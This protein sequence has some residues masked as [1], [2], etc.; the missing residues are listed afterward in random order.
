MDV[1]AWIETTGLTVAQ[2]IWIDVPAKPYIRFTDYIEAG[3]HTL[4]RK[5]LTHN[6]TIELYSDEVDAVSES[7]I[8]ALLSPLDERYTKEQEWNGSELQTNY[9]CSFDELE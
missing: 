3:Y 1:K 4:T 9:T 6:L 5:K 8:E 7:A 2:N